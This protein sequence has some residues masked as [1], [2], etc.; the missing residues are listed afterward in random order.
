MNA[1]KN[2]GAAGLAGMARAAGGVGGIAGVSRGWFRLLHI[3]K[4]RGMR[5]SPRPVGVYGQAGRHFQG[6]GRGAAGGRC[7]SGA[8]WASAG[9]VGSGTGDTRPGGVAEWCPPSGR[10][11]LRRAGANGQSEAR[12]E[13][14]GMLGS[15]AGRCRPTRRGAAWPRAQAGRRS[16][17]MMRGAGMACLDAGPRRPA[18]DRHCWSSSGD[19]RRCGG[20]VHTAGRAR[21]AAGSRT[22][23]DSIAGARQGGCGCCTF[24]GH[25]RGMAMRT[26]V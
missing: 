3:C 12:L 24:R 11:T 26:E 23:L 21:Q 5:R 2:F 13:V 20:G 6:A 8:M 18:G 10:K 7:R 4:I 25:A 22:S 17:A 9:V 14:A 1:D 16:G 19:W 15:G